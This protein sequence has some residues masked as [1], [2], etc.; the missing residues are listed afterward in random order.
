MFYKVFVDNLN[1][2]TSW[3]FIFATTCRSTK[4]F[5]LTWF[6]LATLKFP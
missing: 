2:E 3:E 5:A 4:Y 1:L 6:E